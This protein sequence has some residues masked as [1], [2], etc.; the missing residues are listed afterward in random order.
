[1]S[2]LKKSLGIVAIFAFI[3]AMGSIG[4]DRQA[5]IEKAE[6]MQEDI[7]I[8]EN[9]EAE[10]EGEVLGE[11]IKEEEPAVENKPEEQINI[12]TQEEDKQVELV[13]PIVPVPVE[14]VAASNSPS[15]AKVET[16]VA[17][18]PTPTPIVKSSKKYYTS[19]HHSAKLYYPEDCDGW[20]SLSESYLRSFESLDALLAQYPSRTL[21]PQCN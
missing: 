13:T 15:P 14:K 10:Q 6:D 12:E 19:S 8:R 3:S 1:M 9:A 7:L 2:F 18:K 20:K 16:P 5:K 21:S 11:E 4:N 17:P